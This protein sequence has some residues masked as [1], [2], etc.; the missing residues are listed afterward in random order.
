MEVK[1]VLKVLNPTTQ[2]NDKLSKRE[3]VVTL[4]DEMYPQHVLF[5]VVNENCSQL[6]G[7]GV[8]DE[9]HVQFGLKGREWTSPQG[10]VKY[11]NTLEAWK[12]QRLNS[13]QNNSGSQGNQGGNPFK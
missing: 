10:E 4:S 6:D 2:V 5:Q 9:I 12:I 13:G 11:F 8:G 1:G 7:M 3:F